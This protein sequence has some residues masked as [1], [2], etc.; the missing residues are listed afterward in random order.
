MSEHGFF[1]RAAEWGVGILVGLTLVAAASGASSQ[2]FGPYRD[3]GGE[4]GRYITA[5]TDKGAFLDVMAS[6]QRS[7]RLS[8]VADLF[9]GQ[10]CVLLKGLPADPAGIK[11][12][13]RWTRILD[14]E[15]Y[16]GTLVRGYR[17]ETGKTTAWVAI[18]ISSGY[19]R[20]L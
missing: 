10:T 13:D 3:L 20:T 16:E 7:E 9:D 6:V 1:R 12:D 17:V 4:P 2:S 18:W 11:A 8:D 5:C 15:D 19:G 14:T